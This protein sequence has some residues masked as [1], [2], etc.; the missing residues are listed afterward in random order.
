MFKISRKGKNNKYLGTRGLPR[1]LLWIQLIHVNTFHLL[2]KVTQYM[3]LHVGEYLINKFL[4]VA[5]LKGNAG[6]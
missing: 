2:T 3:F 6:V 5:G 1:A 4:T